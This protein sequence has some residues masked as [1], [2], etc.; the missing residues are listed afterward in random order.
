M[1][2]SSCFHHP[3]VPATGRCGACGHPLCAACTVFEG[4]LD[5]CPPCVARYER[6]GR[7]RKAAVL[8]A[9]AVP[10]LVGVGAL[11]FLMLRPGPPKAQPAPG[12]DYGSKSGLVAQVRADLEREPCNRTRAVQYVHFLFTLEDW[13]GSIRAAD[14]FVARCGPFPQLRSI[15]YSAHVRLSE[16]EPAIRDATELVDSEPG[17]AGYRVWRALVYQGH[18]DTAKALEDFQQAFRLHPEEFQ[19]AHQLASAYERMSQPCEGFRV[20]R[21]YQQASPKDAARPE[22]TT[23]LRQLDAQGP[24]GKGPAEPPRAP[25]KR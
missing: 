22:V 8:V 17:N 2:E 10:L 11:G 12:F 23:L 16:F 24:C 25:G 7:R 9:T 3:Q 13:R 14:D 6:G 15:T 21:E 5:R 20:M 4:G 19:V 18:G 1:S